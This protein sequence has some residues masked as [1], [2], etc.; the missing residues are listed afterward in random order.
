MLVT[1]QPLL[2]RFWYALA[3]L[4]ALKNGPV[5][6]TLLGENLVLWLGPDGAPACLRDRCC[7]RTMKLSK[8][9]VANGTIQCPY[10]GWT[11]DAAGQC[12]RIPQAEEP[13]RKNNFKIDN[14]RC[15]ARHGV[16]W[17]A[18]EEPLQ[19]IP[20]LPEF[21]DPAFRLVPEFYEVWNAP[22]L[23]IME[24][25]FDNAHFAYVHAAS[26]GINE[27]PQPAAL[28][29]EDNA[30]GFDMHSDIPVKNPEIQK[31]NLGTSEERTVRHVVKTW[32]MPFARKMRIRYPSGLVHIICT[33]TAPIDDRRSTVVQFAL[34]NDTE[35][36][37]PAANVV[38]FD[39]QVTN[40]DKAILEE[41]DW[42]V[43]LD[44]KSGDEFHMASDRPGLLMRQRLRALL[45]QQGE[46]EM[47]RPAAASSPLCLPAGE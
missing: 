23:R 21:D 4:E 26:F 44:L 8:G 27:E 31:K 45:T 16:V 38:A 39:R 22:G 24:N 34:R 29:I 13:E 7:H 2:R 35:E 9:R 15:V 20:E 47:R 46:A 25:S 40:E 6:T 33:L 43:P 28:R 41:C 3:P 37:V 11:Y 32:W 1:K 30:A 17:V 5:G 36:Q 12:I 10:H 18:L 19:P 42:D 14:F